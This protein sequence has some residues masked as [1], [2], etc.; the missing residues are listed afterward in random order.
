[1][2]G[3]RIVYK[4]TMPEEKDIPE[5]PEPEFLRDPVPEEEAAVHE[6]E[7]ALPEE[8]FEAR[9]EERRRQTRA[10]QVRKKRL[11][12]LAMVLVFAFLATMCGKDIIRLK[13]ENRALKKQ[14]IALQK[15]RDELK[16]ELES[17]SEQEYIRDQARKQLRLLNPGELLFMFEDE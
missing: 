9:T 3:K 17:T 2:S 16:A 13:A 4:D 11:T 6:E 8:D 7:A 10:K 5:V 1:M 14:Q 12:V 15:E